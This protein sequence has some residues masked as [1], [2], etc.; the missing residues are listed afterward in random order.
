MNSKMVFAMEGICITTAVE[1]ASTAEAPQP[2][3]HSLLL[4]QHQS[5][6]FQNI[7]RVTIAVRYRMQ[8]IVRKCILVISVPGELKS[9]FYRIGPF[10]IQGMIVGTAPSL[11]E[12]LTMRGSN[13][14][15][16]KESHKGHG[17]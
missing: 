14:S 7:P 13:S 8:F 17:E 10:A 15:H 2:F 9:S 6:W 11:H 12:I 4:A 1:K 5:D 3:L 16:G